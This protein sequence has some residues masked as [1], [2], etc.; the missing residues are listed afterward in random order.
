MPEARPRRGDPIV[1]P[2]LPLSSMSMD[3]DA[4][5]G[6]SGGPNTSGGARI[7][8]RRTAGFSPREI[9]VRALDRS[10]ARMPFGLVEWDRS[11]YRNGRPS[12][13][14]IQGIKPLGQCLA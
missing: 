5:V 12:M 11:Q 3:E 7:I 14:H 8:W 9:G 1:P 10:A 13:P 6:V 4:H 2:S